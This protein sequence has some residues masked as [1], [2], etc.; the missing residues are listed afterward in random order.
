MHDPTVNTALYSEHGYKDELWERR[1]DTIQ[2]VLYGDPDLVMIAPTLWIDTE[3]SYPRNGGNLIINITILN[4]YGLFVS[5]DSIEVS[6]DSELITPQELYTGFYQI[7]CEPSMISSVKK[8]RV[9]ASAAGYVSSKGESNVIREY[10]MVVPEI[11]AEASE[12]EYNGGFIQTVSFD[13]WANYIK[14]KND[15]LSPDN[16]NYIRA[17]VYNEDDIYT[18][19]SADLNHVED[20]LWKLD[21]LNVSSLPF[22]NYYITIAASALYG[23]FFQVK[24]SIFSIE[25]ILY[26]NEFEFAFNGTFKVLEVTNVSIFSTYSIDGELTEDELENY[27]FEIYEYDPGLTEGPALVSGNLSFNSFTGYFFLPDF[28]LAELPLGVYFIRLTADTNYTDP[29]TLDSDYF[30]IDRPVIITEPDIEYIAGFVQ[31]IFLD[32]ILICT[33]S[34]PNDLVSSENLVE[35]KY[36]IYSSD[37]TLTGLKGDL[38]LD[39]DDTWEALINTSS[40]DEGSYYALISVESLD[41]GSNACTSEP[42]NVTHQLTATQPKIEYNQSSQTVKISELIASS[43]FMSAP[44]ID[45]LHSSKHR[46]V[47]YSALDNTSTNISGELEYSADGWFAETSVNSLPTGDYYVVCTL[48]YKDKIIENRSETFTI[49]YDL[50]VNQPQVEYSQDDDTLRIYG[51]R[52]YSD[53]PGIG[54]LIP[55]TTYIMQATIYNES[56]KPV[57]SGMMVFNGSE[58]YKIFY[59][60]SEFLKE[61]QYY[62][63]VVFSTYEDQE[64]SSS[65]E[66]FNVTFSKKDKDDDGDLLGAEGLIW[67]VL[68]AVVII[69]III[70]V[71]I[72]IMIKTRKDDIFIKWDD[73]EKENTQ[74]DDDD[75]LY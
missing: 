40:L 1:G 73:E 19:L 63:I 37:D 45:D 15:Y 38:V 9:E 20:D 75:I 21:G 46:F 27:T 58:F 30:A 25:H 72:F 5:P 34:N 3:W 48:G 62:V 17:Y 36:T 59:N 51:L 54:Y 23:P 50:H 68:L 41:Y 7:E 65:S 70:L 66:M 52:P 55:G 26:F 47:I 74:D 16:T 11:E 49:R 42:F 14:P 12:I 6:L 33:S 22:G 43:S 67:W 53:A 71:F 57:M 39:A 24:S 2:T 69:L 61:G 13:V 31:E 8:L 4:Q 32:N 18:G 10:N 28:S 35:S 44:E 29:V 56:G 60:V 64:A